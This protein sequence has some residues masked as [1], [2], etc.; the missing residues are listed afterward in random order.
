MVPLPV[1]SIE[2]FNIPVA[3][4]PFSLVCTG[5]T[6]FNVSGLAVVSIQW[7]LN[8][9]PV[10]NGTLQEVTVTGSESMATLSFSII[11]ATIHDNVYTCISTLSIPDVT[12]TRN[13]NAT[14]HLLTISKLL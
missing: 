2:A 8:H 4:E 6:P 10:T 14:Y 11:N 12:L 5:A 13:T 7:V 3:N 1:I 9:L